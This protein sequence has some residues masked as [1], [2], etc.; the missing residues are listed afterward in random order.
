MRKK[1]LVVILL[2]LIG[3]L[4][5]TVFC[6]EYRGDY[7][8]SLD[9]DEINYQ[10]SPVNKLGRGAVNTVTCWAEIPSEVIRVTQEKD[11]LAGATLGLVEGTLTGIVRGIT[12]IADMLTF[13]A[14][15]YDKPYMKPEYPLVGLAKKMK[16]YLW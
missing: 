11:P 9:R 4:P 5:G 12:G 8:R 3:L 10:N 2:L 1:A 6:Q 14:P 15:P 16:E 13:F 7:R